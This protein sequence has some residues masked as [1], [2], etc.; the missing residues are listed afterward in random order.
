M[1][2]RE[3]NMRVL[4]FNTIDVSA[5]IFGAFMSKI[6]YHQPDFHYRVSKGQSEP[7]HY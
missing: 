5:V 3:R 7:T 4:F 1:S 2:N 6:D